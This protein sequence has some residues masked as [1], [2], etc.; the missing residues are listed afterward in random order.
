MGP[1]EVAMSV[2]AGLVLSFPA[3]FPAKCAFPAQRA[4]PG[5]FARPR[6]RAFPGDCACPGRVRSS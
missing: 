2:P 1:D 4:F 5:Q 6:H 3:K